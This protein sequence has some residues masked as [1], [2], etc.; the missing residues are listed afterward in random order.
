MGFFTTD[1]PRIHH[2]DLPHLFNEVHSLDS[3]EKQYLLGK[4]DNFKENHI[5]KREVVKVI[6]ELEHNHTDGI[7]SHEVLAI[8]NKLLEHLGEHDHHD[9]HHDSHE[10]EE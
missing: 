6:R 7:E 8:K 1:A 2:R 4:F 3:K 5:S 9:S 10:V